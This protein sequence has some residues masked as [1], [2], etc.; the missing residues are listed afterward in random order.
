M[1]YY[2]IFSSPKTA[3]Q[4]ATDVSAFGQPGYDLATL[5]LNNNNKANYSYVVAANPV[6]VNATGG[7]STDTYANLKGAFDAI[8]AGLHTGTITINIVANT[9]ETATASLNASGVGAASFATLSITP[10]GNVTVSGSIAINSLVTLDG[11]D[12]VTIDGLNTGG[13]YLTFSNTS[14]GS[15]NTATIKLQAD[16]INNIIRNCAILGSST[17][18]AGSAGGNLWFATGTVTG[19]DNNTVSNCDIGP[20]GS[21]LPATGIYFSGT[22]SSIEN[23]LITVSNCNIYDIF[24][25]LYNSAGVYIGT[26]SSDIT[27]SNNKFYQTSAKTYGTTNKQLS[28][29]WINNTTGKYTV[30]GNTIGYAS[31]SAIG[32]YV[33][34]GSSSCK[35]IPISL[36]VS[37]TAIST[38]Q[39]NV[40][41]AIDYNYTGTVAVTSGSALFSAIYAS[42][43]Y[44]NVTG[45]TIGS[46]SGTNSINITTL[47]IGGNLVRGI[48][49]VSTAAKGLTNI[50]QTN[51][52]SSFTI[53]SA[54]AA[55][56]NSMYAVYL[57]GAGDFSAT[58]NTIGNST[59]F[60]LTAGTSG[61]TTGFTEIMGFFSQ[62]TG[63]VTISTNTLQNAASYGNNSNSLFYGINNTGAA[64]TLNINSNIFTSNTLAGPGSGATTIHF[65]NI[66]NQGSVTSAININ[67]N[68]V[69]SPQI[70]ATTFNGGFAY[71]FISAAAATCTSTISNNT[72]SSVNF[73]GSTGSTGNFYGIYQGGASVSAINGNITGNNFNN[74]SLKC[75]GSIFIIYNHY[76]VPSSPAGTKV[77]QNN[78]ITTGFTRSVA[79]SSTG[80]FYIYYD[81]ELSGSNATE[82]F[83]GNNFSNINNNAASTGTFNGIFFR[84][85]S[86]SPYPIK[87]VYN[88]TTSNI[89]TGA[90]SSASSIFVLNWTGANSAF[91]NNTIS[92]INAANILYVLYSGS[93]TTSL[94]VYNNT[95]QTVNSTAGNLHAINSAGGT[96]LNFYN[97]NIYNLT[98]VGSELFG[99]YFTGGSSVNIYK[100]KIYDFTLNNAVSSS[101]VD[102]ININGGITFNFF[103]NLIGN[104][105]APVATGTNAVGGIYIQ[106]SSVTINAYYNTIYLNATSSGVNFGSTAFQCPSTATL[107]L[108]NNIIVNKSTANGTG[109]TVAYRRTNTT[110]TTYTSSSN[111]NIFY[112]GVPGAKNLIFYDATNADQFLYTYQAR[113]YGRDNN[114]ST[115]DVPFIS[116]VGSNAN[117]LHISASSPTH[118]ERGA[119]PISGYTDDYDN[120]A[121]DNTA[122]DIGADEFTST[123]VSCFK[124][125]NI[126]TSVVGSTT[127]TITWSVPLTG[128]PSVLPVRD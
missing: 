70:T 54:T 64:T 30:T 52:I 49:I 25:S 48:G 78:I 23:N 43:G 24:G 128:S 110:L 98:S 87:F 37:N 17:I 46:T 7:L 127:A 80:L 47:N 97:N 113:V 96:L 108:R 3:A 126:Y 115:E 79:S 77:I 95:I 20:A 68:I 2:Y 41:A 61:T 53:T 117:F 21:N 112:S 18:D 50:I 72:F 118:A 35:F 33:V 116:T 124:P 89:T 99:L 74:I 94:D 8:N 44:L 76:K 121:R 22:S 71:V 123:V 93:S 56:G 102:G 1:Y 10:T 29:I 15:G 59:P 34:N 11:A 4:L 105:Y 106:S 6:I 84:D 88:N 103:N 67:S 45:N 55:Y 31:A 66:L 75:S 38:I 62:A 16:A 109:F 104:L 51:T 114:S 19:N 40:I 13:N 107:T 122:P 32:K 12:N 58:N 60:S 57:A 125:V 5:N 81:D 27:L 100:N 28:A 91:Y 86:A 9:T 26:G 119:L 83:S 85:G 111:N 90:S 120:Q 82:T 36:L 73:S 92:N 101:F 14:T 69:N 42:D 63:A 65:S 39:N